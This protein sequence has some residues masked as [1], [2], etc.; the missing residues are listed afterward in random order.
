MHFKNTLPPAIIRPKYFIET[1]ILLLR[2]HLTR[3][4]QK[5][6]F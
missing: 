5:I 4:I 3:F 1:H 2:L 6:D